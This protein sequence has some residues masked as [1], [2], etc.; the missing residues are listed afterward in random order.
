MLGVGLWASGTLGITEHVLGAS[1]E[2]WVCLYLLCPT[3]Q[4]MLRSSV[5]MPLMVI[6]G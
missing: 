2:P 4:S 1:L 3:V 5:L 6:N